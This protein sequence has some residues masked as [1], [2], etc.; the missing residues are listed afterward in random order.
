MEEQTAKEKTKV[1]L[2]AP[3]RQVL[4]PPVGSLPHQKVKTVQ[5]KT[6]L[7]T[8]LLVQVLS[9]AE[10]FPPAGAFP[11][12]RQKS[13]HQVS[14]LLPM[15]FRSRSSPLSHLSAPRFL[16]Q[17][18]NAQLLKL[19]Q[20]LPV[21]IPQAPASASASP[22][23]LAVLL[24]KKRTRQLLHL[25]LHPEPPLG[26]GLPHYFQHQHISSPAHILPVEFG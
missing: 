18:Q 7:P 2:L 4:P 16:L 5:A 10:V 13:Q 23:S 26:P 11:P 25:L 1:T 12:E 22:Y 20:L 14:V 6:S 8:L 19:I 17:L 9:P 24:M 3:S 21:R 15:G